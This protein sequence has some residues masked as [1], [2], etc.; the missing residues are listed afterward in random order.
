MKRSG[1]IVWVNDRQYW[2][3]SL[4][5]AQQRADDARKSRKDVVIGNLTARHIIYPLQSGR[6]A[7]K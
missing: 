6:T 7:V 3:R 2:H 4:A 1:Y 5:T